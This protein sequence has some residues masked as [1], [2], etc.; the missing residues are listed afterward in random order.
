MALSKRIIETSVAGL[1]I[2]NARQTL[3]IERQADGTQTKGSVLIYNLA[4]EHSD[5]IY[6]RSEFISIQAGYTETV[7]TVFEGNVQRVRRGREG[8]AYVTRI[9]LGDM[10]HAP[11]NLGG[12]VMRSYAGPV[13]LRTIAIDMVLAMGLEYGP[14]D[15]IPRNATLTNFSAIAVKRARA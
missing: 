13:S 7:A 15:A 9:D 6:N 3:R 12:F 2:R 14:L 4:P 10:V 1:R 8:L 5:Q 11:N